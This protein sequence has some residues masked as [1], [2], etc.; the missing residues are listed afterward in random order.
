MYLMSSLIKWYQ[1]IQDYNSILDCQK[2]HDEIEHKLC[3]YQNNLSDAHPTDCFLYIFHVTLCSQIKFAHG[4][5][6]HRWCKTTA[7]FTVNSRE[8]RRPTSA[9][10]GQHTAVS[11]DEAERPSTRSRRAEIM[12]DG[13]A[14]L[15]PHQ[16]PSAERW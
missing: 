4:P 9:V 15:V 11:V 14:W 12:L 3:N 5:S 7:Q 1:T 6:T 2:L 16:R 13:G 8:F 10:R